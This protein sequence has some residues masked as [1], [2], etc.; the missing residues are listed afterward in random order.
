M[1]ERRPDLI[2]LDLMMPQRDGFKVTRRL[3]S[4]P[5]MRSIPIIV[6]TAWGLAKYRKRPLEITW[7]DFINKPFD[8]DDLVDKVREYLASTPPACRK[9]L[10]PLG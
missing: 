3:K 1:Q 4:D 10:R 2:L 9:R 7:D 6:M 8:L 5:E